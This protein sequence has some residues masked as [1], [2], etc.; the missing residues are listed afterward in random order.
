MSLLLLWLLGA[1]PAPEPPPPRTPSPAPELRTISAAEREPWLPLDEATRRALRASDWSTALGGLQ[2]MDAGRLTG[3]QHADHAFLMGWA[4][5]HTGRAKDAAPLVP[6]LA[7]TRAP[8]SWRDVLVGEVRL[9]TD[10]A[11]GAAAAFSAVPQAAGPWLRAQIGLAEAYRK[12]GRT[13]DGFAVYETLAR[14][15]DPTPGNEVALLALGRRLGGSNPEG[16]ALLRRL[17][18]QYPASPEA[19][20][21]ETLLGGRPKP[22]ADEMSI[23]GERRAALG[24]WRGALA[25]TESLVAAIPGGATGCR[26]RAVRGRAWYK[27][28]KLS[29]AITAYGDVGALCDGVD[30]DLGAAGLYLLGQA[31]FRTHKMGNSAAHFDELA[32]R[33][34]T[35]SMADDG[36]TRAGIALQEAGD[37]QGAMARWRDGLARYP[38]GD[39]VPEATWRLAF[40]QY[41]AGDTAGARETAVALGK[42]D[43]D[44]DAVHVH[45]G[46][47][48]AARW[49]AW[50][51]AK[52]PTKLNPAG[53]AAAVEGFRRLCEETP[54][55]YYALLAYNR[56][57]ELDPGAA[58]ALQQ[59]PPDR[60]PPSA[61]SDLRV[62]AEVAQR[63]PILEGEALARLGLP[64]AAKAAWGDVSD[65]TPSEMAWLIDLRIR[66]GDWLYAHDDFRA[67]FKTNAIEGIGP[68]RATV[69]RI[70]WPDRYWPEVKKATGAMSWESRYLHALVREES[71]FNTDIV[72]HAG[73]V[74]LGQLMP[75]TAAQVAGWLGRPV[76][77]LTE[78]E[79]NLEMAAVYLDRVLSEEDSPFLALAAYNAGGG[80]VDQWIERYGNLP[81]D[82]FVERIP[83][84]ETRDYVKRVTGT[85]QTYRWEF[86]ETKPFPVLP[87]L[88]HRARP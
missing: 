14:R 86:D 38:N 78:P 35:D 46:R 10:D 20:Q 2:K 1:Q 22:T 71:N 87:G 19:A 55:S 27:L 75:A 13:A 66:S 9:A 50:P 29:N 18:V 48:W 64:R 30:A 63:V 4:L 45:A 49:S 80:R 33:W 54:H 62:R 28:N 41:L 67:W 34:P 68:D 17:W 85:W 3:P 39:T 36:L 73:A 11:L 44:S 83:F 58:A 79:N 5:A 7:Q 47:Y 82:E 84:R 25:E 42:L 51:D 52:N 16:A 43:P 56:L 81:T 23:R 21:A 65:L 6:L 57:A 72:S 12:L 40:A 26:V 59:R 74:G 88:T 76:G 69:V 61:D 24:D 31:E 32:R 77:K 70:A 37:L 53:V 8:A 60:A 15:P